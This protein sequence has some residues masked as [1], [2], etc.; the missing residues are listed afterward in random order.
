MASSCDCFKLG[1]F[2]TA[3]PHEMAAARAMLTCK[4]SREKQLLRSAIPFVL[5]QFSEALAEDFFSGTASSVCVAERKPLTVE[6]TSFPWGDEIMR[7]DNGVTTRVLLRDVVN[8]LEFREQLG[9]SFSVKDKVNCTVHTLE[10][11]YK[12]NGYG[13]DIMV[14]HDQA[15]LICTFSPV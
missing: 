14:E 5:A 10:H 12:V 2:H 7:V 13:G 11:D 15:I 3:Q 6:I 9:A 1:R 8:L 4:C